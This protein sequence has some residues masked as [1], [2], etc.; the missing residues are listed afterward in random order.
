MWAILIVSGIYILA[1]AFGT[2]GNLWVMVSMVRSRVCHLPSQRPCS[3]RERSRVF[4]FFLAVADFVVLL[5]IPFSMAQIYQVQWPFGSILCRLHAAIDYSGKFFS[6]VILT[7]MSIERYLIVC[8][9]WRYV[10]SPKVIMTVPLIMG[11]VF[12]VVV[13]IIPQIMYTNLIEYQ[14]EYNDVH[15]ICLQSMPYQIEPMYTTYTFAVGFAVPLCVMAVCY[16]QLVQHVRRKFKE[17]KQSRTS[18]QRPKYM[19]ELTRSICRIAV[20]HFS[21]WAPFWFYNMAPIVSDA[22]ELHLD[23]MNDWFVVGRLFANMLPYINSAGNCILYA[24][25]NRDIRKHIIWRPSNNSAR[26][27]IALPSETVTFNPSPTA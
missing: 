15:E 24:F 22:F 21:C 10:T 23:L 4:I 1:F 3:P 7:A 5:T 14:D 25:L 18:A 8:T 17:R 20:F 6:V 12:C 27:I 11:V 19:C 26:T 2:G 13:P 9:R 16:V